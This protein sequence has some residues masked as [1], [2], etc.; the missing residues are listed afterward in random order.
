MAR[1]KVSIR[2]IEEYNLSKLPP[3]RRAELST[4]YNMGYTPRLYKAIQLPSYVHSYSLCIEYM[5]S[6]F[7]KQ[8]PPEYFKTVYVNGRHVLDEWKHFNNY[9]IKR[10]KPMLAVVPTVNYDWDRE[11]L[12]T[13]L[14]DKNILLKRSNANQSFFKDWERMKFI[15]LQMREMEMNY[16]FKIRVESRAQQLDLFNRM[17]LYFKIGSIH[18]EYLSADFHI[19]YNIILDIARAAAF[20]IDS[21]TNMIVDIPEFIQY[22]NKHSL[23]PVVFKMRAINQKP[24]FFV[25]AR[26]MNI[27][28]ATRDKLQLDDGEKEGKLDTNYHVE[29]QCQVRI[30][31]PWFFA[32]LSQDPIKQS[33]DVTERR[34]NI[35]IYTIYNM[36]IPPENEMGWPNIVVTSYSC[37]KDETF[38]DISQLFANPEWPAK[39]MIDYSL[40]LDL[41]PESFIDVKIWRDS[42]LPKEIQH[43]MDFRHMKIVFDEDIR[44]NEVI[45]IAIYADMNY[46]NDSIISMNNFDNTRINVDPDNNWN[47]PVL[48]NNESLN[49]T[50]KW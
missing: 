8:F 22:M 2:E 10:E 13:Y 38:I 20:D 24:E 39:K 7:L 40:S 17:E 29:M 28:I 34:P 31:I 1:S 14:A 12:D 26:N 19:P 15:Y 43:H 37:G 4:V 11:G 32:Y 33:I 50:R 18:H 46:I 6:W 49:K 21:K 36:E 25:R 35:G 3:D 30:P 42:Y 27:R 23:I 16:T 9:N 45:N 44:T 47:D 5:K 41:S 48:V